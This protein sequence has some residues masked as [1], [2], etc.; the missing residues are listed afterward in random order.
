MLLLLFKAWLLGEAGYYAP[1]TDTPTVKISTTTLAFSC[2]WN[3]L[4]SSLLKNLDHLVIPSKGNDVCNLPSN[5]LEKIYRVNMQA[6]DKTNAIK[7]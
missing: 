1:I 2:K 7:C 4:H 5:G 6:Y 3:N